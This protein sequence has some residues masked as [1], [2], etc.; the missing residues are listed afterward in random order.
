METGLVSSRPFTS[1][2]EQSL[3]K[4]L[5]VI[6]PGKDVYEKV[7]QEKQS[8]AELY[9]QQ[10]AVKTKPHLTVANFMAHEAMEETVIRYL[11]R[12]LNAEKSFEVTLNNYSGFPPHTVYVRVQDHKPFKELIAKL[13][14]VAQYV[15]ANTLLPMKLISR[16]HVTIAK[17]LSERIYD[18]AMLDFS[19][20][21]FHESFVAN[22][23]VLLRTLHQFDSCKQVNVFNLQD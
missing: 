18:K 17:R 12:I 8:F 4:Y 2:S 16:P 19:Q 3:Y 13:Q 21:V 11:H 14:P 1:F 7:M 22:K 10:V 9:K 5:L 6:E 23:L 20:R 15:K